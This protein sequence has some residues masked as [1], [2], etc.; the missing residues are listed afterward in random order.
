MPRG[1][2]WDVGE[3]LVTRQPAGRRG[4]G[5]KPFPHHVSKGAPTARGTIALKVPKKLP[6]VL[7]AAEVQAILDACEHPRDRLLFAVLYD[8]GRRIGEALGLRHED[9]AAAERELTVCRRV[10]EFGARVKSV[11]S[12]M[13]P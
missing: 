1:M 8:S 6:R 11:T 4:G 13:T 9:L 7:S 5:W 10:N 3:P 2:A 12:R